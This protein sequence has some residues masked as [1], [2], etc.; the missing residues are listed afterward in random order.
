[1]DVL[2]HSAKASDPLA[3]LDLFQYAAQDQSCKPLAPV[4]QEPCSQPAELLRILDVLRSRI[5]KDQAIT[6]PEIAELAN[7]NPESPL[8]SRGGAVRKILELHFNELPWPLVAD[9][10][11]YYRPATAE[12]VKHYVANLMSRTKCMLTRLCNFAV[13]LEQTEYHDLCPDHNQITKVSKHLAALYNKG[14]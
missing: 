8:P 3:G 9:N 13:L 10:T 4:R 14:V 12:E 6:A 11:G 2:E 7:I 5:G 1:M